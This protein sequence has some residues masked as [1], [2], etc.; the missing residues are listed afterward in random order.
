MNSSVLR[1]GLSTGLTRFY[2]E[3]IPDTE[4]LQLPHTFS[5]HLFLSR[6]QKTASESCSSESL[7]Y[8]YIK[9]SSASW[10]GRK[11]LS[12]E[13]VHVFLGQEMWW[14]NS[15]RILPHPGLCSPQFISQRLSDI[16][17]KQWLINPYVTPSTWLTAK[18]ST[19]LGCNIG[20]V[21]FLSNRL[22]LRFFFSHFSPLL[23]QRLLWFLL[24]AH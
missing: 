5:L 18:D 13:K 6:L 14:G 20:S 7:D 21:L 4:R 24:E 15:L 22:A 11:I 8:I 16:L 12:L 9:C 17:L 1:Q 2:R 19:I 23:E 3:A 10:N